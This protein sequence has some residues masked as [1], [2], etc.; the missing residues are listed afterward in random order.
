MFFSFLELLDL[1]IEDLIILGSNGRM[2]HLGVE[3]HDDGS[4]TN[5]LVMS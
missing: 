3:G 4:S 5:L 2:M 1:K